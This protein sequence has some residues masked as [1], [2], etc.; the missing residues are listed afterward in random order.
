MIPAQPGV[1]ILAAL[2]QDEV[3]SSASLP[4]LLLLRRFNPLRATVV[5]PLKA[6]ILQ[7]L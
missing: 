3:S 4:L 2:S 6:I 5:N 1:N 7:W